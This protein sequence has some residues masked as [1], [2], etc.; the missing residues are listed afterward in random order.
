MAVCDSP[1]VIK[2]VSVILREDGHI[3]LIFYFSAEFWFFVAS[4][5]RP[6]DVKIADM[7]FTEN[8]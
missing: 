1:F 4:I 2:D 6:L 7:T 8:T 5:L 3:G